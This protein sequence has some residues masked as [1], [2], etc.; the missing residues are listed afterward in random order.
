[1]SDMNKKQ[2]IITLQG[3]TGIELELTATNWSPTFRNELN[4]FARPSSESGD[5]ERKVQDLLR[6]EETHV[7]EAKVSD[8]FV[9]LSEYY[10]D[11]SDKEDVYF[12][13]EEVFKSVEPVKVK[14]GRVEK[15][16][17]LTELSFEERANQDNSVLR[18]DF[19]LLVGTPMSQQ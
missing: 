17:Y 2:L 5:V 4:D 11:G 10:V 3:G 12:A 16:G 1:M 13:L 15:K 8:E 18:I 6:V 19:N 9:E 14:Y 7:F